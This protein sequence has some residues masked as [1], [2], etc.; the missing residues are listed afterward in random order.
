MAVWPTWGGFPELRVAP[1]RRELFVSSCRGFG[2]EWAWPD[3]DG[4]SGE[5]RTGN[6][7]A[8]IIGC[9]GSA[10]AVLLAGLA[11]ASIACIERTKR[12]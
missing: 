2:Q 9:Q 12:S 5:A 3:I 10:V 1:A 6:S 11:T 8:V 7:H 4:V